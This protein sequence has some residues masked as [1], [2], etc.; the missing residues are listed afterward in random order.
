M[1][2]AKFSISL[3]DTAWV[4]NVSKNHPE[5]VIEVLAAVPGNTS[6]YALIRISSVAIDSFLS[7]MRR[8]DTVLDSEILHQA[9]EVATV[10][11]ETDAPV[12][13]ATAQ[14]SRIPIEWPVVIQN[15]EAT[16]KMTGSRAKISDFAERLNS[17]NV[18]FSIEYIREGVPGEELLSERQLSIVLSALDHGY[19]DTPRQCTL[20]E[21]AE[22]LEIAKSTCSDL[23]H[24]AEEVIIKEFMQ[25]LPERLAADY[26]AELS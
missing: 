1:T 4:A 13:L 12:L 25:D 10:Q 24:R 19:Y 26:N 8:H 21:L 14:E 5:A 18:P 17:S 3:P 16:V 23:L 7:E 6:G 11:F 15:G 22:E 20:T 2:R 9:S